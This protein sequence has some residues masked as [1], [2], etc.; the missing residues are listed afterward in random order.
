MGSKRTL[1]LEWCGLVSG[2]NVGECLKIVMTSFLSVL[3]KI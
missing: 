3:H 1:I 2:V